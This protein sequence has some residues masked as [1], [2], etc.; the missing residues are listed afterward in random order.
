MLCENAQIVLIENHLV[1]LFCIF[2]HCIGKRRYLADINRNSVG[3][4]HK[5]KRQNVGV[6]Q[7][8]SHSSG[9]LR[10]RDAVIEIWVNK[11]RKMVER[12]IN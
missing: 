11:A 12:I 5:F 4:I 1:H 3:E 6:C 10:Q 8:Q 7:P 2:T 9:G